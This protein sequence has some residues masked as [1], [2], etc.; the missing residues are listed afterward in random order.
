M[1][2]ER[3]QVEAVFICHL[4]DSLALPSGQPDVYLVHCRQ[5]PINYC[6]TS[7]QKGQFT[8]N[9]WQLQFQE[10]GNFLEH[11]LLGT[12]SQYVR[13]MSHDWKWVATNIFNLHLLFSYYLTR[14]IWLP[15]RRIFRHTSLLF[16][17]CLCLCFNPSILPK[18]WKLKYVSVCLCV[19][20][21]LHTHMFRCG[22]IGELLVLAHTE[23]I[24]IFF[25]QFPTHFLRQ[26]LSLNPNLLLWLDWLAS[27]P[28]GFTSFQLPRARIAD[29]WQAGS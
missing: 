15:R 8:S 23:N 13:N 11:T 20:A 26:A 27:K 12:W 24:T 6:E 18:E 22:C 16:S 7:V 5:Q 1:G 10:W 9:R 3:S 25:H 19:R 4:V 29:L 28:C 21:R 17:L 2:R 14:G